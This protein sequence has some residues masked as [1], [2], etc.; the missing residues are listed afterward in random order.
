MNNL[1]QKLVTRL[2]IAGLFPFLLLT[3]LC[4]LMPLD[5]INSVIRAQLAYGIAILSF[6]G[7]LH[8]GLTIMAGGKNPEETKRALITGVIPTLLA[9]CSLINLLFGFLVQVGCFIAAYQIDKKLYQSY[10]VPDWFVDLRWKLTR[11]VIASQIFTFIIANV[12]T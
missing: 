7:G 12:R 9:W 6:L 11:I 4:L 5:L 1:N 8:W 2:G 10:A 3:L